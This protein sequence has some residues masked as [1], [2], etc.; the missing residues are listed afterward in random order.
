VSKQSYYSWIGA[1]DKVDKRF[2][3]NRGWLKERVLHWHNLSNGNFGVWSICQK[4]IKK[5]GIKATEWIVRQLMKELNI[6]GNIKHKA[7]KTTIQDPDIPSRNDLL[8]QDFTSSCPGKKFVGDITYLKVKNKVYYLATVID[9]FNRMVVGWALGDNMKTEL[10]IDALKMAEK[11]GYIEEGAIF[12]SDRGSQY[13]SNKFKQYTNSI[14]VR[15]STGRKAT[16]YDNAVAESWFATF[17]K[18]LFYK[19]NFCDFNQLYLATRHYIEAF[20][21][22][23]RPHTKCSGLSPAEKLQEYVVKYYDKLTA[24]A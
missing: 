10:I 17:K 19:T 2:K 23:V 6:H 13:T 12:H 4:L 14:N 5:D 15:L 8:K 24:S 11:G 20:Y 7:V 9:L 22:I 18:E 21:N 1:K 16:C 3:K